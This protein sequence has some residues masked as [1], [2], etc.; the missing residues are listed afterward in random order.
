MKTVSTTHAY[1]QYRNQKDCS[2]YVHL[3][4][5]NHFQH[6][7]S[8]EVF[9]KSPEEKQILKTRMYA[10]PSKHGAPVPPNN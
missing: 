6:K 4:M 3:Q 1:E 5:I 2:E 8:F 10:Y 7:L 9:Q